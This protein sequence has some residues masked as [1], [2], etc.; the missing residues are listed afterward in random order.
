MK[1]ALKIQAVVDRFEDDNAI[2]LIGEDDQQAIFPAASL[3][4]GLLLANAEACKNPVQHVLRRA[5][6]HDITQ[7]GTRKVKA[8]RKHVIGKTGIDVLNERRQFGGCLRHGFGLPHVGGN[9][10]LDG[11]ETCLEQTPRLSDQIIQMLALGG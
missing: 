3:P 10:V 8:Y 2:L 9:A 5:E 7:A 1:N 11:R 4:E 6:A